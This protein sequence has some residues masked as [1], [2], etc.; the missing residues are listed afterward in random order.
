LGGLRYDFGGFG[1]AERLENAGTTRK[2]GKDNGEFGHE[3]GDTGFS[4]GLRY[5]RRP[6][7]F[8]T[9]AAPHLI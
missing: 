2:V 7:L 8:T 3:V 1:I 9:S 4:K 6:R 5:Y